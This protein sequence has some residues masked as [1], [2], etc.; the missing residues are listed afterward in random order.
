MLLPD[1]CLHGWSLEDPNSGQR[2]SFKEGQNQPA[3]SYDVFENWL[4]FPSIES[5][6]AHEVS[7]SLLVTECTVASWDPQR[8]WAAHPG[9]VSQVFTNTKRIGVGAHRSFLAVCM[10]FKVSKHNLGSNFE[11]RNANL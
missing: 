3:T 4:R 9:G 6:L 11:I 1:L 10:D 8:L 2:H 7:L 5:S